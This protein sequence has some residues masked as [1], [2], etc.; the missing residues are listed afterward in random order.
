M[1]IISHSLGCVITFDIM[2][3]WDPVRFCLQEHH[4]QLLGDDLHWTSYEE[5]HLLEEVQLTRQRCRCFTCLNHVKSNFNIYTVLFTILLMKT[6][7][8]NDAFFSW[9]EDDIEL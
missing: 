2:T 1:S 6:V 3:G 8:K 4:D 7:M 5:R 9:L